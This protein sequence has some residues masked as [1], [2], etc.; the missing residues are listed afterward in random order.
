MG[1]W[2]VVIGVILTHLMRRS[3]R[4]SLCREVTFEEESDNHSI[5]V[6]CM[7]EP[8]RVIWFDLKENILDR[9]NRIYEGSELGMTRH[10]QKTRKNLVEWR[11]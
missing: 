11:E 5:S 3:E 1:W 9:R 2:W 4:S 8:G 10:I 7:N 6:E